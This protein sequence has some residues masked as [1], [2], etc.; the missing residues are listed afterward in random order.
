[1]SD[2]GDELRSTIEGAAT[3][4]TLDELATRTSS[5]ERRGGR[6]PWRTF[7]AGVAAAVLVIVGAVVVVN[8]GDDDPPPTRI[9]APTVV[10][11]DIDLAVLSTS[12]DDDGARGPIDPSVVDAVR[13]VPGVAGAQGAMQRFVDVVPTALDLNNQPPAS[14]RSAIAISWEDGAPLAFSAGGPP[15]G[16]GEVAINQSLAAQ[17]QIGVGAEVSLRVGPLE[18]PLRRIGPSGEVV[19]EPGDPRGST[20]RVVGVFMPAGGDV[21]DINLVVMP[22]EDL[23]IA[24]NKPSFDRIDIVA[25]KDVVIDDLIDR[26]S[27]A[28]PAGTMAVPPSVIGFDEQLRS[29]LEIQRAYHDLLNPDLARRRDAITGESDSPEAR[30]QA[31]QNWDQ[32]QSQTANTELR[33]SR[34][35]FLDSATAI[36][37]YRAY[38]GGNP[39]PVVPKPLSG[40]AERVD[41]SWRLSQSGICE[42]AQAAKLQCTSGD[43]PSTSSYTSPPNGW[44]APD[45]VLGAVQAFRVI[46]DP[47]TSVE[48][49]LA[50]IDRSEP[51]RDAIAA[52]AAG[53]RGTRRHGDVQRVRRRACSTPRTRRSCTPSIA[54]GEPHLETPYPLVGNAVL[55]NGT[56]KVASRFACGLTALA[57]LSCP[58]AAALPTTT[59]SPTTTSTTP[60][61][62]APTSTVPPTTDP[63]AVEVPTTLVD[64]DHDR[65]LRA[66]RGSGGEAV[67]A[68]E[69]DRRHQAGGEREPVG[70]E[71]VEQDREHRVVGGHAREREHTG[72]PRFDEAEAAG[73]D[74]DHRQRAAGDERE[75]HEHR[76]D[77]RPDREQAHVQREEVEQ[78]VAQRRRH[79]PLP[80]LRQRT[81]HEVARHRRVAAPCSG[82]GPGDA[83]PGARTSRGRARRRARHDRRRAGSTRR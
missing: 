31:Q 10:V 63:D 81:A 45:S 60:S 56:W 61:T 21:E 8:L 14:E 42:L 62:T 22:A 24:T 71:A 37:T 23:G 66:G 19:T 75:Q 53:R 76:I 29:E 54:E 57:T 74:R 46:A 43:K 28:L 50:V 78:L 41:G 64:A 77:V 38:Y 58:P 51:L 55:V 34:V 47:T 6:A 52:G 4:V 83:A 27:A 39:S 36:V 30:A 48:Q 13:A 26:V 32:N 9:A 44:N 17:Y 5:H 68:A 1:M 12:F 49:R 80:R 70:E 79:R 25:T 73:G 15:Q 16:A 33:V 72:E 69:E 2:L 3:P 35:T 11:G 20:A 7:V 82:P 65:P 67:A 18:G 59:T 40:I